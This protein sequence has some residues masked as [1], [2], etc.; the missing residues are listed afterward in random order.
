MF[1]LKLK[2][3]FFLFLLINISQTF[4]QNYHSEVVKYSTYYEIKKEKLILTDSV[5][6]QINDRSGETHT[7][8]RIPYTK[9][10]KIT[11]LDAWIEDQHGNIVRKLKSSDIEDKNNISDYS[12]YEDDFVKTFQ[13]KHNAYPYRIFY[14]YKSSSRDFISIGW[15]PV[16]RASIPTD[17]AK[18]T[19]VTPLDYKIKKHSSQD[20]ICK[21]DSLDGRVRYTWETSYSKPISNEIYPAYN[22]V[23]PSYVRITPIHFMYGVEGSGENWSSFGNWVYRLMKDLDILPIEEKKRVAELI[24]GISDKK[25]MV[26]VLYHYMQDHTRYVNVTMDIGGFKPYPASYVAL[27]K[28]G[29]CKALSNYMKALLKEAGINAY[30]TV[31]YRGDGPQMVQRDYPGTFYFNHAILMVPLEKDTLWLENTSN[32]GPFGMISPD[33]QGR[34]ALLVDEFNS[35][36]IR[37][38]LVTKGNVVNYCKFNISFN[39]TGNASIEMKATFKG[40]N[41][42]YF[43]QLKSDLNK[44]EQ[45]EIIHKNIRIS[46]FDLLSWEL[47]KPDRDSAQIDLSLRLTIYKELKALGDEEYFSTFDIGVPYFTRPKERKI[48]VEIQYPIYNIDTIT[49]HLPEGYEIKST[50]ERIKI[51]TT[52]GTYEFSV[53]PHDSVM[54][55]IKKLELFRGK[56]SLTEYPD[57][58]KFISK[59]NEKENTKI[60]IRKKL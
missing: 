53:E 58:Y 29:D 46:N 32:I 13:L 30:Y 37:T 43:N 20:L 44:D 7:N 2:I 48:P 24:K 15:N 33:I 56:Y 51:E 49:Y 31:V 36:I 3:I 18:L 16:Y 50:P 39:E 23:R 38:P 26:K 35:K 45:N 59:V 55:V 5:I 9:N 42:E 60:L 8:V 27:N 10:Q 28:Y 25:Q 19:V 21:T 12:L 6:I 11:D 14:T 17:I 47:T 22:E 1:K 54:N 4:A 40:D 34:E 52:Y 57:F 41:F